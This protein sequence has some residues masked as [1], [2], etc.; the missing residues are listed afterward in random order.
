MNHYTQA[1]LL[2]LNLLEVEDK[3]GKNDSLPLNPKALTT[4]SLEPV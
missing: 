1:S 2:A 3:S 4:S